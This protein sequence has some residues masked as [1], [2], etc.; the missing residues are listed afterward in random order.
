LPGL[1]QLS[2]CVLEE[3]SQS[4]VRY[5]FVK[6]GEIESRDHV[7]PIFLD[8]VAHVELRMIVCQ[9]SLQ[10]VASSLLVESAGIDFSISLL[11]G[12]HLG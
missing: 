10:V 5:H 7:S 11:D 12:S 8:E 3:F 6:A 2:I 1:E 9:I 4:W